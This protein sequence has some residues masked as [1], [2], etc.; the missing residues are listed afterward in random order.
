MTVR[1]TGGSAA[2]DVGDSEAPAVAFEALTAFVSRTS[3][4]GWTGTLDTGTPDDAVELTSATT[5]P[6]VPAGSAVAAA[7]TS[8]ATRG[9]CESASAGEGGDDGG[10]GATR[11]TPARPSGG[12]GFRSDGGTTRRRTSS[13]G[14]GEVGCAEEGT[15]GSGAAWT[16][17]P[18]SRLDSPEDGGT[19][20][21]PVSGVRA[22]V[23]GVAAGA[24]SRRGRRCTI[25]GATR[26]TSGPA[27]AGFT[28]FGST[29]GSS[30]AGGLDSLLSG[31]SVDSDS[32]RRLQRSGVKS[33][34]VGISRMADR[35]R[36]DPSEA[37]G[38]ATAAAP[39]M[40]RAD[41]MSATDGPEAVAWAASRSWTARRRAFIAANQSGEPKARG[42]G[43]GAGASGSAGAASASRETS[44]RRLSV[45]GGGAA[46]TAARYESRLCRE[47]EKSVD[48]L[49]S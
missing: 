27:L 40:P 30:E 11:R 18:G 17:S 3:A 21:A 34:V 31:T 14:A 4:R 42:A 43:A 22:I 15:A 49:M 28:T 2:E 10:V 47:L 46:T 45:G 38:A 23:A 26:A 33:P 29:G 39:S 20:A 48:R 36:T 44:G 7:V 13:A 35:R 5:G 8:S 41:S 37:P 16:V 9:G 19:V 1:C 24:R 12:S 6:G 32:S 25:G